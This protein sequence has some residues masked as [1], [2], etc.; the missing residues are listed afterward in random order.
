M[1]F[2]PDNGPVDGLI[3]GFA[4]ANGDIFGYINADDALL[5]GAISEMVAALDKNPGVS[6]VIGHG[7]VIDAAGRVRRCFRS[8]RFDA[9]RFALGAGVVVQQSTFFRREAYRKVGGFNDKNRTSWDAEL[10][11]QMGLNGEQ[12]KIIDRYWSLF[13]IHADSFTG[14][15]GAR[16]EARVL[17]VKRNHGRYFELVMGR[18]EQRID[19]F[20]RKLAWLQ[21]WALD[22]MGAA[23]RLSDQLIGPPPYD[24]PP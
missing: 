2:E 24:F 6:A 11:L 17:E 18:E 22:P 15:K 16:D 4:Q 5:P 19:H 7:Y 23:R 1:I 10:L 9:R 8:A 14:D 3:K 13:T 21:R 12:I 20:W